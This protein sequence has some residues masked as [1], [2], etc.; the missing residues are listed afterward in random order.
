MQIIGFYSLIYMYEAPR[1]RYIFFSKNEIPRLQINY[2][3]NGWFAETLLSRLKYDSTRRNM[4]KNKR[5]RSFPLSL[6]LT[7]TL[8][9]TLYP[10]P[11]A[12]IKC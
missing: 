11:Q 9:L 6:T 7:L 2:P 4:V 1:A 8:T 3:L 10:A 12:G 5:E